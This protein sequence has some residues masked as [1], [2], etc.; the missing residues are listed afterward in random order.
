MSKPVKDLVTNEYK[1]LFGD[2]DG[3]CVVSVIG[4]DAIATNKL[5]GE[6]R[7]RKIQMKVVKNSLARRAFTD[8]PLAPLGSALSGPCALVTGESVIDVAKVLVDLKKT[9][10]KI[11][12]KQGIFG[13]EPDLIPLERLASMKSKAEL[14]GEVAMLLLSPGGKIA[15]CLQSPG[16][17]IAGCLKAIV[18][19]EPE[20]GEA[21][22]EAA[23]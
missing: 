22:P 13:G 8:G 2:A 3:A 15:G 17:K 9:Y 12:L 23:A 14:L 11:E 20:G 16:G 18:D 19:K 21:A 1:R 10:P 7:N 6:L 4:L 5:R